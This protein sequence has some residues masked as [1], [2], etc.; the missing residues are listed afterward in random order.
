MTTEEFKK[1]IL[2]YYRNMYRVA[3]SLLGNSDE[4]AD[5]VQDAILKLWDRR[6]R[7]ENIEDLRSYCINTMR[8]LCINTMQRRKTPFSTASAPEVMSD[9]DLHGEIEWRDLSG[10]VDRAMGRLSADQK[11][12][13][14]LSAYGGFSNAEIA[15][16]LGTSQGNVRVL[17]SR[18]RNRLKDLLKK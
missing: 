6:D 10:F 18:A 17:L 9:E 5:A 3:A 7:L 13:L 2:P 12:V 8:N 15:D 1:D 4:A 11:Y 14:K 16:M